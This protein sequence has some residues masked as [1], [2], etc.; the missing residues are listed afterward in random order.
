LRNDWMK[1]EKR[2]HKR[3]LPRLKDALIVSGGEECFDA[4]CRG[5]A[6]PQALDGCY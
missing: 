3:F 4:R 2:R 1:A 6:K 5:A